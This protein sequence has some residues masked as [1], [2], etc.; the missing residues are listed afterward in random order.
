[1]ARR[2]QI[3]HVFVMGAYVL[4]YFTMERYYER[5]LAIARDPTL[6]AT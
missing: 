6:C 3:W 2:P 5:V 1:M 4:C